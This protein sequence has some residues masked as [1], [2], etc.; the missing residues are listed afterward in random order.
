MAGMDFLGNTWPQNVFL[1]VPDSYVGGFLMNPDITLQHN[2]IW[3]PELNPN[4]DWVE[5]YSSNFIQDVPGSGNI[6]DLIGVQQVAVNTDIATIE[7]YPGMNE[8]YIVLVDQSGFLYLQKVAGECSD[9][10]SVNKADCVTNLS[11]WAVPDTAPLLFMDLSSLQH[12]IGLGSFANYDERGVLGLAFHPDYSNNGKFYVYYMTEQGGGTGAWGFPLSTTVISEFTATFGG[13]WDVA[14]VSSERIL[15]E[16]PQPDFN[17]NGGEL[18]FGPDGYLYIGLGDG[19]SAGDVSWAQG[20]G[21]HGDYGNAQNPTNFLGNILRIDVDSTNG[22]VPYSIPADNPFINSIYKEGQA[23]AQPFRPEIYAFGFRNPWRFSFDVQGRLWCADVGQ[24]KFEEVNIVEIGGNYG[25]RVMEA[26][27]YYEE[28]Q[29]IIDQIAIDLGYT[30]TLEYLSDLKK[31]IHEYSHGTGISI[32][33]GFVYQGTEVPELTGKYVFGDWGTN[34]AGTS[35]RLYTLE[36]NIAGLSANFNVLPNAVNG[37]THSHTLTL[38]AA[39]VDFL[40]TNP[41]SPVV[42]IQTDTIHAEFYVHTFTVT[43]SSADELFHIIGQTNPEGHDILEFI[44]WS[45]DVGYTRKSLSFWDPV[46]EVVTLTTFD[47]SVLSMGEDSAG[48]IYFSTRMGINTFQPPSGAGPDNTKIFK[49]TDAYSSVEVPNAPEQIPSTQKAHTHGYKV[50]YDFAEQMFDTVEISDIEM[51]EWDAFWPDWTENEPASHVH[52]VITAWSHAVDVQI[53]LGSSAGW[54]YNTDTEVWGPYDIGADTAWAPP[55]IDTGGYVTIDVAPNLVVSIANEYGAEGHFHYFDDVILDSFGENYGRR[56]NSL[57]QVAA[58]ILANQEEGTIHTLYSSIVDDGVR[59]H[60]HGYDI[61]YSAAQRT[62]VLEE[63]SEWEEGVRDTGAYI[64]VGTQTHEHPTSVD[65]LLTSV[66]WNGDPS[67]EAPSAVIGQANDWDNLN[68]SLIPHQ[69][70]FNDTSLDQIGPNS[71]RIA[72]YLSNTQTTDLISGAIDNVTLYSSIYQNHYHEYDVTFDSLNS[73][74]VIQEVEQWVSSDNQQYF[75][76]TPADHR[77]P[78]SVDGIPS[79]TGYNQVISVNNL[80]IFDSPGFPYP[81]GSHPHFFN[82][83]VVGPFS[84]GTIDYAVGL[85]VDEAYKLIDGITNQVTLYDSISGG[86]FHLYIVKW[87]DLNN[88]FY[89]TSSVTYVRGGIEDALQDTG[90]YYLSQILG[91]SEGLHWHNLTIEWNPNNEA[92]AQQSGGSIYQTN[93]ASSYETLVNPPSVEVNVNTTPLSP[94]STSYPDTPSAGDDTTIITYSDLTT[95]TTTTT[96]ITNVTET[97]TTNSSDGTSTSTVLPPVVT[98]DVD[99]T[100]STLTIENELKRKTF[101]NN[102]LQVNNPPTIW[103]G[104]TFIDGEGSHDHLLYQ[105]CSLDTQGPYSGRMC[106]PITLATANLLVNSQDST[107]GTVWYDSPNGN[108]AHYHSYSLK[109]NPF[110]GDDGTFLALPISQFDRFPGSGTNVHKFM[111]S[112]GFHTHTYFLTETEYATLVG[113]GLVQTFQADAI[114]AE[115]YT[116]TL[117]IR[118]VNFQYQIVSQTSDFDNHNVVVYQGMVAEGGQWIQ[119]QQGSGLGDHIHSTTIDETN[120]WPLPA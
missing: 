116:H 16:V 56:S 57:S 13:N 117:V 69:H 49:I 51:P 62:F 105:G 54:Y 107:F 25:W 26:Y 90:R 22:S 38:T 64:L 68:G 14:D 29:S 2:Q 4:V 112:G 80:P 45:D 88:V 97:I 86:H 78:V 61:T 18:A 96:T 6:D 102:I 32:L 46:T 55:A 111:L 36:E 40:H 87:D 39:E 58:E 120:I 70:Y 113:G 48:E 41:G 35:G 91:P 47:E 37:A 23:E 89:C 73:S 98:T 21:G 81:G 17:H 119:S 75:I 27:H 19:G 59:R 7:A 72:S 85:S 15:L 118:L 65:G 84:D 3:S 63:T 52:P 66:G 9:N 83:T 109:F 94:V 103:I 100:A 101:V 82:N 106:E 24:D 42:T 30:T 50:T 114:H 31:P 115:L 44:G 11:T 71:D 1:D 104:S 77:H 92:D 8:D 76:R 79:G 34:W 20:H 99:V 33:G 12:V 108:M 53:P 10:T 95:T 43:Y 5:I 74:L 93:I 110:L 28:Q 67:F 60:Y